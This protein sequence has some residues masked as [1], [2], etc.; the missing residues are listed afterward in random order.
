VRARTRCCACP[1]RLHARARGAAPRAFVR[2]RPALASVFRRGFIPS[3]SRYAHAPHVH[4]QARQAG[5]GRHAGRGGAP[6]HG[7]W[8]LA[9]DERRGRR[10][11]ARLPR[12][13]LPA[14][15]DRHTGAWCC[16]VLCV[17]AGVCGWVRG[18]RGCGAGLGQRAVCVF[19]AGA[20]ACWCC[21][22]LVC[23]RL[24]H[25]HHTLAVRTRARRRSHTP[26]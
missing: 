11:H 15:H 7:L 4:A 24:L 9:E 21:R 19:G 8:A 23:P 5:R 3:L 6:P 1:A 13:R 10:L 12:A 2:A 16:V 14:A 20:P 18:A 17:C 22:S 25:H 26:G